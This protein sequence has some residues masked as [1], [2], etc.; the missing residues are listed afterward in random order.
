[1]YYQTKTNGLIH[2]NDVLGFI[3]RLLNRIHGN[4][5]IILDNA[6]QHQSHLVKDYVKTQERLELVFL[7]PYSPEL[8][9]D[10]FV[11]ALA[12]SQLKN[13]C[14]RDRKMLIMHVRRVMKS[15]QERPHTIKSFLRG[16][17]LPW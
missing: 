2:K 15:I 12:K 1:M 14:F 10:E 8:N 4:L 11:W 13:V 16:S 17:D 5:I 9:P 6:A 3:I 7:P